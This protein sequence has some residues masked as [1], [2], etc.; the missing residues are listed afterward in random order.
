MTMKPVRRRLLKRI[1]IVQLK[2]NNQAVGGSL[3]SAGDL[4]YPSVG[5]DH[6][7]RFNVDLY[8]VHADIGVDYPDS[9]VV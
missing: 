1:K 5:F 9:P 2:S 7:V 6:V 3:S 8:I 4:L